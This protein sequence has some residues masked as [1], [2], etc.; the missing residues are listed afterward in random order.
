MI[1][2]AGV[3]NFLQVPLDV[4]TMKLFRRNP[5]PVNV[6]LTVTLFVA[7]ALLV[8]FVG[9]QGRER[10]GIVDVVVENGELGEGYVALNNSALRKCG[11]RREIQNP[12]YYYD[13]RDGERGERDQLIGGS[14]QEGV[15]DSARAYGAVRDG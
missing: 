5:I 7:G 1:C 11:S 12:A 6:L 14:H 2:L 9:W 3:G 13:D 15:N 4:L 10:M 8:L